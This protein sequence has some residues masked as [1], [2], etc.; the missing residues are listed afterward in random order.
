M[1]WHALSQEDV[2]K[3]LEVNPDSGL[4]TAEAKSRQE[5]YGLNI[6]SEGKKVSLLK[7]FLNQFKNPLIYLLFM[8]AFVAF[9]MDEEKDAVVILVVVIFNSL[10]GTFQEGK[11]ERSLEALKKVTKISV[12]VLRDGE[13]KNISAEQLV[14]GDIVNFLA[15]DAITADLRIIDAFALKASEAVLT[16][17]SVPV[18]KETKALSEKLHLADRLNMLYS[19][20]F[21]TAGRAKAVVTATG[22]KSEIGQIA[23]LTGSVEDSLTT[24]ETKI[25]NFSRHIIYASILL[26]LLITCI[27]LFQGISLRE[28][29]LLAIGQVVSIVPEGLPVAITVAA[30]VGVQRMAQRKTIVR[31]LSAVEALGATTIICSDK[32]GTLTRNEM[33]V[34][35]YRLYP[36]KILKWD[37]EQTEHNDDLKKLILISILCNDAQV[38]AEEAIGDPTETSLIVAAK[39]IGILKKECDQNFPRL[40]EIPFDSAIKMMATLHQSDDG[41]FIAL[42]G[43]PDE[44][45][46]LCGMFYKD[47]RTHPL[48][49]K[50]K[51]ELKKTNEDMAS[52]ALRVLAFA[53]VPESELPKDIELLAGK[54]IYLGLAGQ[55][56]PPRLE[57]R[58]AISDC[59]GAGI[60]PL[61]ITGDHKITGLA[62]AKMI[63]LAKE[64]SIA[65]DGQELEE[66]PLKEIEEKLNKVAVFARVHP[67][68]KLKI[69]EYFQKQGEVVAMTGDG[70]ND[71][72][73]LSKADVGVAMGIT[74]TEVAKSASKIIITDDNF[75]TIVVAIAQ[76]RLVYQNIRKVILLLFSTS[77]S[78]VIV[79]LAALIL[80]FP[81]PYYAV[82][83]LWNN[84]VTDGVITVNLIMEPEEGNE[85]SRSPVSKKEPLINP[86][87]FNRMLLIVPSIALSTFGWFVWRINMGI[88]LDLVRTETLTIL[89]MCEW[90]NALNCRSETKTA[91]TWDILRNKWLIGALSVSCLLHFLLV[92]WKPLGKHFHTVPIDLSILPLLALCA[93]L[94]LWVEETRKLVV[95]NKMRT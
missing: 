27:G 92:F 26:F 24:L 69:V 14:P 50:N 17:E 56:D 42:K 16:G 60:R 22:V 11:A 61:M 54:A 95:R 44:I 32:T 77:L 20:T 12:R 34:S 45:I 93:S 18:T 37:K 64:D 10:I 36:E 75:S 63:G 79:L 89:I 67:S 58:Q 21:I 43:S 82:Q 13:E 9:I 87:M 65:M 71:A 91:F 62:I 52:S 19:G 25:K 51:N 4:S 94:V 84:L 2:L 15:G 3:K 55:M 57:V 86:I 49:E 40:N 76:G 35:E 33:I 78:E 5:R 1:N 74:G 83:I 39:K 53:Y 66:T 73:A 41:N 31:R 7:V 30:V 70:V 46:H 88:E 68:Q 28:I 72:P 81:A 23:E 59:E 8:A 47:G 38:N 80:G 90:F 48:N 6:F 85:L 29:L